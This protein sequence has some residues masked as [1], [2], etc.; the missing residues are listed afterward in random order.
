MQMHLH[1]CFICVELGC[2]EAV[3]LGVL[4]QRQTHHTGQLYHPITSYKSCG[5]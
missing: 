3:A 5:N 4:Q 2:I 1:W